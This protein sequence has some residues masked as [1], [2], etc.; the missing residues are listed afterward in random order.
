MGSDHYKARLARSLLRGLDA[1]FALFIF[2]SIRERAIFDQFLNLETI[3]RIEFTA[4][5]GMALI[6]MGVIWVIVFNLAGMYN[7]RDPS[8]WPKRIVRITIATIVGASAILMGGLVAG[9]KGLG[10]LFPVYFLVASVVFFLIQRA[11]LYGVIGFVRKR[12]R[13]IRF[14]LLVGPRERSWE[15]HERLTEFPLGYK[16][17]GFMDTDPGGPEENDFPCLGSLEEFGRFVSENPVDI[18]YITLPVKSYYPQVLKLLNICATQRIQVRLV[19]DLFDLPA[20]V[21]AEV[22][23]IGEID[24]IIYRSAPASAVGEDIKRFLDVVLSGLAIIVLTPVYLAVSVAIMLQDGWPV[25]F[26]QQ[27]V[28]FNKRRFTMYKFRTM[29]KN[30][31]ALQAELEAK[32]EVDGATFKISHDP[33]IT[34]LGNFLRKTSLDEL[35]QFF[36]VFLGH[37]SLVGPRPLPIRDFERFYS[38]THRRRFSVK[39]GVT[40]LWQVSGR[41]DV[42]FDEWMKLDVFYVDHWSLFLDIRILIQTVR[43]VLTMEGAY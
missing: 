37:M 15:L 12:G 41:S 20:G 7:F 18:V 6:F 25:I 28:G 27:R 32:N 30:A 22:A 42:D 16:F 24:Y 29:V 2:V 33:R 13:N 31:E 11:I 21:R 34:K 35:P 14:V 36:N 43:V 39:P 40:G 1:L 17:L 38:D 4:W 3:R 9:V 26:A 10:G 23:N 8:P 19:T 5:H